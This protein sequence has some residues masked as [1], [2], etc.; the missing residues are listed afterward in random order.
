VF[1]AF[2]ALGF[3]AEDK[4]FA[5]S[6]GSSIQQLIVRSYPMLQASAVDTKNG[7]SRNRSYKSKAANSRLGGTTARS[8][9]FLR[10]YQQP[11]HMPFALTDLRSR[12][13]LRDQSLPCFLERHQTVAILLRHEKCACF[14]LSTLHLSIGHFYFAR[15]GHY[16]F[17]PTGQS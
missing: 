1:A 14:H 17:A 5:S 16:H 9:S 8:P 3:A 15:L 2:G 4:Y 13:P 10:F 6:E 7:I 12:F 11:S